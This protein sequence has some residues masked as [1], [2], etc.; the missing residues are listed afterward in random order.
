MKKC[1]YCAEYI[2][3]EAILCRYCGSDLSKFQKE[4]TDCPVCGKS[5]II[6]SRKCPHCGNSLQKNFGKKNNQKNKKRGFWKLYLDGLFITIPLFILY[7]I[8]K[9][10]TR[11]IGDLIFSPI[12]ILLVNFLLGL[13]IIWISSLFV[14]KRI[15]TVF[16][17]YSLILILILIMGI[18][19]NIFSKEIFPIVIRNEQGSNH[20]TTEEPQYGQKPTLS[21]DQLSTIST[22][23]RYEIESKEAPEG[24]Q[25][26]E[27]YIEERI[28]L[29]IE[30]EIDEYQNK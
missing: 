10:S 16:V 23:C 30:R 24:Y 28:K 17:A 29:C 14:K 22:K 5:I 3:D 7:L 26:T 20:T 12:V 25:W 8:T 1:P 11:E 6:G 15:T 4:L 9:L 13:P 27:N 21:N 19:L 2:Q 18:F